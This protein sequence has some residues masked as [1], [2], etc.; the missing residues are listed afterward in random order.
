MFNLPEDGSRCEPARNIS[1]R[2]RKKTDRYREIVTTSQNLL[3]SVGI[4]YDV[5][6]DQEM[7]SAL[8]IPSEEIHEFRCVLDVGLSQGTK[9]YKNKRTSVGP[10]SKL[11]PK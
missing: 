4:V 8:F 9:K 2:R 11:I 1:T 3:E 7:S 10:S 6:S 5:G